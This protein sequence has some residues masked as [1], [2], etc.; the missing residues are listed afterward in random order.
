MS[1][2][3]A[4]EIVVPVV[5]VVTDADACLPAGASKSRFLRDVGEGA[6][7]VVLVEMRS[8]RFSGLPMGVELS[9]VGEVDVEPAVVVVIEKGQAAS[10]GFDDDSC[11]R[12][13]PK[14]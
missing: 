3:A 14:R 4:E 12:W 8:G 5:V 1:P 2:E 7:A 6:V 13:R 11:D 10:L 9:A